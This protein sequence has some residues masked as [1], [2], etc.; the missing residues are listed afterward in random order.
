M[1]FQISP[2]SINNLKIII[3]KI[4][5][6]RFFRFLVVGGINTLFGYCVFAILI[7]LNFY[8]PWALLIGTVCGVLFNFNT[9]GRIVF[10]SKDKSLIFRFF[11]IYGTT[12]GMNYAGL[13][14]FDQFHVKALIGGAV[15]LLPMAVISYTLNKNLV[16]SKT[17]STQ[18]GDQV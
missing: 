4:W 18:K 10:N 12:Y 2:L 1:K 8:Y 13:W 7:L 3:K 9:T 5:G 15:L 14:T 6:I 11:L 17:I 16:F